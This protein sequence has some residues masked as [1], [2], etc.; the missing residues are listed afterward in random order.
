MYNVYADNLPGRLSGNARLGVDASSALT[1]TPE[2]AL[3]HRCLVQSIFLGDLQPELIEFFTNLAVG[4]PA[5]GV[6]LQELRTA[7]AQWGH[8]RS[9][10]QTSTMHFALVCTAMAAGVASLVVNFLRKNQSK[11]DQQSLARLSVMGNRLSRS[12]DLGGA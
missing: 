5:A 3:T 9:T 11:L 2:E 10:P 4:L 12:L 8:L 1:R 6:T 7:F